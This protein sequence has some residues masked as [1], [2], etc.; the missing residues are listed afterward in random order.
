MKKLFLIVTLG[1]IGNAKAQ[2]VNKVSDNG[3]DDPYRYAVAYTDDG[4]NFVKLEKLT[5]TS[6]IVVLYDGYVCEERPLLEF[7]F[8]V[9]ND[10]DKYE[11]Y[12][13]RSTDKKK[14]M[15]SAV[16]NT[17][18]F[19]RSFRLATTMRIRLNDESCGMTIFSFNMANSSSAITWVMGDRIR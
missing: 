11:V 10:N 3:F 7:S 12:A 2:W 1:L 5:D 18:D 4:Q 13:V 6:M 16:I 8:K 14:A 17:G 15:T 9:G 19:V